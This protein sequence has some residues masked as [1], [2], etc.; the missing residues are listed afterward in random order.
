MHIIRIVMM[1]M[2][3]HI[4]VVMLI[5]VLMH[6]DTYFYYCLIHMTMVIN[7]YM[8]I[9]VLIDID[10]YSYYCNDAYYNGYCCCYANYLFDAYGCI[11][12][13]LLL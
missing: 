13:F 12:L 9:I 2:I 3:M 4:V 11:F 7:V 8:H 1:H 10:A 5:I 6:T